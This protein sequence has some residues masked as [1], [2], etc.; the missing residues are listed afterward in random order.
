MALPFLFPTF[1]YCIIP[2][3]FQALNL[4]RYQPLLN[5]L[6]VQILDRNLYFL[7]IEGIKQNNY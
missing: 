2:Q 5:N 3:K 1:D 6:K 7:I 4:Y